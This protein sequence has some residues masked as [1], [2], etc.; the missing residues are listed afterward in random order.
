MTVPPLPPLV[1]K[2][3]D[4][5]DKTDLQST[6]SIG[7]WTASAIPVDCTVA[8]AAAAAGL[9]SDDKVP[10]SSSRLG[11]C[12]PESYPASEASDYYQAKEV[13][14][15]YQFHVNDC[16]YESSE[17]HVDSG[18]RMCRNYEDG[19]IRDI[20]TFSSTRNRKLERHGSSGSL[21]RW[22]V[23]LPCSLSYLIS[24]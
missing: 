2:S 21:F 3:S 23:L 17:N 12:S 9:I 6:V 19:H 13:E 22:K 16:A 24:S 11:S 1:P 7:D 20:E 15:D 18:N 14:K 8:L 4:V 5:K 10:S